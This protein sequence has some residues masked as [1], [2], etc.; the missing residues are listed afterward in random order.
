M[1]L[2][3]KPNITSLHLVSSIFIS[4]LLVVILW[5]IFLIEQTQH[6]SFH[7]L[8]IWPRSVEGIKGIF[9]SVFIHGDLNHLLSNTLPV[10]LLSFFILYFY[11]RVGWRSIIFIWL[12]GGL[13]TWLLGRSSYHIGASGL[14]YGMAA[15]LVL[16]GWL[17]KNY[18]LIAIALLV[19]FL[20]GSLFWGIFPM[21]PDI[22]WEAHA[23]GALAGLI[24]G[25]YFKQALPK[26]EKYLWELE[27]ENEED[28]D[29]PEQDQDVPYWHANNTWNND[30]E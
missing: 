20:Y 24:A 15:F 4:G 3:E 19:V 25:W 8:G 14:I 29:R 23:T 5:L 18:R 22:S 12:V 10:W 21:Q 26:R 6:L 28:N 17:S 13:W 27:D 16:S 30:D 1:R 2:K 11:P 9:L 7:T